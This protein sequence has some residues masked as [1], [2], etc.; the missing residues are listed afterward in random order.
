MGAG[1]LGVEQLDLS[2]IEAADASI[3]TLDQALQGVSDQ[4]ATLGA[5]QNRL[6][7]AARSVAVASENL[8]ASE[9]II[10]NADMASAMVDY[11]RNQILAQAGVAMLAQANVQT[12]SVLQLLG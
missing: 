11:A 9:S 7:S 6:E 10:R 1:A 4:R 2:D 5:S 8:Q 12:Q 3:V